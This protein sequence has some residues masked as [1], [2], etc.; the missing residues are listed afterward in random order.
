MSR[1]PGLVSIPQTIGVVT[2]TWIRTSWQVLLER[3]HGYLETICRRWREGCGR[4][5]GAIVVS[6]MANR[7][8]DSRAF[9]RAT[10]SESTSESPPQWFEGC[11]TR[12][13]NLDIP[14]ALLSLR[15]TLLARQAV[16]ALN[17]RRNV[18]TLYWTLAYR[19][20]GSANIL[21]ARGVYARYTTCTLYWAMAYVLVYIIHTEYIYTSKAV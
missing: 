10:K 12:P 20:A 7:F 6:T 15:K 13:G 17:T 8:P 9:F 2:R 11:L 14:M 21:L 16:S 18:S 19:I 5:Q 3:R 1:L 4:K